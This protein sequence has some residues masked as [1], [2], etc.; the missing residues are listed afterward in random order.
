MTANNT[1]APPT[2]TTMTH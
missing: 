2:E 1:V